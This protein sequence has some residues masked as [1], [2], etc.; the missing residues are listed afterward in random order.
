VHPACWAIWRKLPPEHSAILAKAAA[1]AA[2]AV[3]LDPVVV[4]K[5]LRPVPLK[6]ATT[7]LLTSRPSNWLASPVAGR[8]CSAV[9]VREAS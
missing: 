9:F 7:Q 8:L 4:T 6:A 1:A 3:T 5:G 2:A